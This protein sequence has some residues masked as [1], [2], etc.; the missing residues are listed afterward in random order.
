MAGSRLEKYGTIFSRVQGLLRTGAMKPQNKPLW[1]D[2]YECFPPHIEPKRLL[3]V[4]DAPL[5]SILYDE[6]VIRAKFYKDFGSPGLIDLLD[7]NKKCISKRF[8]EK[9][10]E[11]NG[12]LDFDEHVYKRT[13]DEINA[14]SGSVKELKVAAEREAEI[15]MQEESEE[16][17]EK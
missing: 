16:F 5:R 10:K 8:L 13:V 1:F 4:P 3:P 17:D 11:L 6:D 7:R 2:V 12:G 14:G 15:K 9:Y